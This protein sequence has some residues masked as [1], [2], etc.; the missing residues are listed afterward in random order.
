MSNILLHEVLQ[1]LSVGIWHTTSPSGF[2]SIVADGSILVEPNID[3]SKRWKTSGGP[4][5]YP[6]VRTLGGVSL[7]DFQGFN[8]EE[9]DKACAMC[10]W[11]EFV[12]FREAWGTSIWLKFEL[13]SENEAYRT[14]SELQRLQDEKKAHR[15]TL[16]PRIEAAHIGDLPMKLCSRAMRISSE[17]IEHLDLRGNSVLDQ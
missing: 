14:P 10:S 8:I 6:F 16:M 1:A 7:F 3:D 9:Y 11:R 15:H 2:Q 4:K 12:P 17:G 13:M 5:Y